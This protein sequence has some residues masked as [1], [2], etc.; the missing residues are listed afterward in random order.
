M[1]D[2]IFLF[3]DIVTPQECDYIIQNFGTDLDKSATLGEEIP[4]YRTANVNWIRDTNNE[5]IYNYETCLEKLTLVP[6]SHYENPHVIKY[7]IGGEYKRH[8]DFFHPNTD[9]Y[10]DCMRQA[11]QRTH[12]VILYLNDDFTGGQTFFEEQDV[13]VTPQKGSMVMWTNI[14][15]NRNPLYN[16]IHAGLPVI[17]GTK[18]IMVVWIREFPF[19]K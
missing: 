19:R 1:R 8:H 5:L 15:I 12:T 9:Y 13:M 18:Y 17:S 16:T 4:G 6:R 3:H 7:D 2:N 14:D 10:V 11:G